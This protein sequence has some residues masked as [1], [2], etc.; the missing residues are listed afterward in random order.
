MI[1]FLLAINSH[2]VVRGEG[3]HTEFGKH[4]AQLLRAAQMRAETQRFVSLPRPAPR[5]TA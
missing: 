1:P 5:Q 2:A 4:Y 3:V